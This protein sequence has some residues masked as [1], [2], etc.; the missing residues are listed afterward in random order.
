MTTPGNFRLRPIN[1]HLPSVVDENA[2]YHIATFDADTKGGPKSTVF[3][4]NWG[5]CM[6]AAELFQNQPGVRVRYWCEKGR[7]RD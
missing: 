3:E 7:Y 1:K 6:I 5:N 2:R 4:Y